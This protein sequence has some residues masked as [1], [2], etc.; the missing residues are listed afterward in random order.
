MFKKSLLKPKYCHLF[1]LKGSK[2]II[3]ACLKALYLGF[4]GRETF[5]KGS[6]LNKNEKRIVRMLTALQDFNLI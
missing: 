6:V 4:S 5:L 3:S 1:V 2:K